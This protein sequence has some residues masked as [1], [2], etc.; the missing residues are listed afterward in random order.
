M[1]DSFRVTLVACIAGNPR[2]AW[3]GG[4]EPDDV[5]EDQ[6][7]DFDDLGEAKSFV[8]SLPAETTTHVVLW[9][10]ADGTE[11]TA[12]FDQDAGN[13]HLWDAAPGVPM[14]HTV[15]AGGPVDDEA[16]AKAPRLMPAQ[17]VNA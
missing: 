2:K 16:I 7:H 5:W 4:T 12:I 17:G 1:A 8:G 9:H 15:D 3:R 10:Q 13:D 6:A 14:P 11:W